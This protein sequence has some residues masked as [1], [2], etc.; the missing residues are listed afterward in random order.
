MALLILAFF[1]LGLDQFF[2]LEV[3]KLQQARLADYHAARPVRTAVLFFCLY[4]A[5]TGLSIP[6]AAIMTLAAGAMFGLLA[7]VLIVSF[8]STAGAT[9]AFLASR[10]LFRQAL[11]I[12]YAR[13]LEAVNTGIDRD[14]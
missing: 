1:A 7:G 12:R 6:V 9:L 8:A 10:F 11:E 13:R 3:L 2:S 4:V 5:V 14:G